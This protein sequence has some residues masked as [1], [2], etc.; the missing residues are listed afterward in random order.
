[1]NCRPFVGCDEINL[2]NRVYKYLNADDPSST[3]NTD[4]LCFVAQPTKPNNA[5]YN[6]VVV[7]LMM[8][9]M[10]DILIKHPDLLINLR[11]KQKKYRYCFIGAINTQHRHVYQSLDLPGY[12]YEQTKSSIYYMST[13][14]KHSEIIKFLERLSECL[15]VFAPRGVGSSSFRMYEAMSVGSVPI[16]T[17]MVEFPFED[18]ICWKQ[19]C[20]YGDSDDLSELIKQTRAISRVEYN[21]FRD[22]CIHTWDNYC[23]HDILYDKLKEKFK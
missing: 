4:D 12:L 5:K 7:P 23:K 6:N 19:T 3:Y 18:E 9:D 11:R 14:Q 15:Y 20:L 17:D 21:V 10:W 16:V 13:E 2:N 22:K 1:M 8:G